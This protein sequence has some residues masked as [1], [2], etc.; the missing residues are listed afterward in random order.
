MSSKHTLVKAFFETPGR[1]LNKSSGSIRIRAE[2][3]ASFTAGRSFARVLDI[4]CGDGSISLPLLN[5]N[6]RLTLLDLSTS[7]ASI[8]RANVPPALAHRVEVRNEDFMAASFDSDYFDL[9]ICVGVLAHVVSPE[10]FM[11]KVARVLKPQ[12]SLILQFTDSCHFV[13]RLVRLMNRL[14][15]I[16]VPRTYKANLLSFTQVERLCRHQELRLVSVFRYAMVPLPNHPWL[17]RVAS[18]SAFY[19]H[20]RRIFGTFGRNRNARLG[21]EY[22]CLFTREAKPVQ[23][24]APP[25]ENRSEFPVA[26]QT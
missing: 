24:G 18:P 23:A 13:G 2:T 8:A 21:N 26:A 1:Y 19:R 3:V 25:M 14:R 5:P 9:V 17:Q 15:E 6:T 10:E 11:K 22:M 12:G 4:G 16:R 7:M 20:T